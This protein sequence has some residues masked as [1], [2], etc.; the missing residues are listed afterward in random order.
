MLPGSLVRSGLC[1]IIDSA[2][3]TT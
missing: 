1:G 2:V 3:F